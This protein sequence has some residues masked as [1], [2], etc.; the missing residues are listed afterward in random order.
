MTTNIILY[1]NDGDEFVEHAIIYPNFDGDYLIYTDIFGRR[2][3][4]T[5]VT[6][7]NIKMPFI[8]EPIYDGV[9]K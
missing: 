9:K 4:L 5:P 3:K 8:I 2:W 7:E 6:N 1:R